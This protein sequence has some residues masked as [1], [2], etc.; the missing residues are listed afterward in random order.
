[1]TQTVRSTTAI[2]AADS[3]ANGASTLVNA[4]STA[5]SKLMTAA[6]GPKLYK[7]ISPSS[8]CVLYKTSGRSHRTRAGSDGSGIRRAGRERLVRSASGRKGHSRCSRAWSARSVGG[9]QSDHG[10]ACRPAAHRTGRDGGKITRPQAGTAQEVQGDDRADRDHQQHER[11]GGE[12]G[13]RFPGVE[14]QEQGLHEEKERVHRVRL[15]L[16]C[17]HFRPDRSGAEQRSYRPTQDTGSDGRQKSADTPSVLPTFSM[18][19]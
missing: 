17:R 14:T 7:G 12:V 15:L 18:I 4:V 3:P 9:A 1:R 6:M 16:P 2:P 5:E 8:E 11:A 10:H 13:H 19:L